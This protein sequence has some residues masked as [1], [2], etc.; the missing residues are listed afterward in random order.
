VQELDR[1]L[2]QGEGLTVVAGLQGVDAFFDQPTGVA[3]FGFEALQTFE[4]HDVGEGLDRNVENA[5]QNAQLVE[6]RVADSFLIAAELRVVDLAALGARTL[7]DPSE[8]IAVT[9]AQF[10]QVAP[11]A[12]AALQAGLLLG[13][14]L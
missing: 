12:S 4:V 10:A 9:R 5:G 2:E 1:T 13:L 8:R 3:R 11:Q 14:S 7:F 6:G